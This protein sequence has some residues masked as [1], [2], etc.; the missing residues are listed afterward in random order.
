M[1]PL[2]ACSMGQSATFAVDKFLLG[3]VNPDGSA[4]PTNGW[5]QYG[6]NLDNRISTKTSTDLCKPTNGANT[7]AV[8]PDGNEGI[9]NSFGKNLLPIFLGLASD[10]SV[11]YNEAIANGDFTYLF[12]LAD[13]GPGDCM[14]TSAFFL[15][16]KLGMPPKFDGSDVWPIDRRSLLDATM[17]TSAKCSFANTRIESKIVRG[18][19][20]DEFSF[21]FSFFSS[22]VVIPIHHVRMSFE[23][24]ADGKSAIGGQIGGIIRRED[25]ANEFLKA[26]PFFDTSFCDPNSPTLQSIV[27]QLRQASDI[28]ADGTQDPNKECDGISIGLGFTLAPGQIGAV[29]P[30][31]PPPMDPCMP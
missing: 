19:T 1:M 24:S 11:Q 12:S 25:F 26:A 21:V 9:D 3:D 31:P 22:P 15:G 6:F 20:G 5:K 18:Q 16:D 8:Y 7:A 28:M 14:T 27:T 4:N 2:P 13:T 10:M 29:A 23:L 30:V 17:P